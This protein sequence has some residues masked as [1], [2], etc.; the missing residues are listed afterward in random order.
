MP[1]QNVPCLKNS[2]LLGIVIFPLCNI[3]EA[4]MVTYL[5]NSNNRFIYLQTDCL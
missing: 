4:K 5:H 2:I 1:Q 3:Y